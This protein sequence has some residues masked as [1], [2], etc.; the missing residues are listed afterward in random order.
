MSGHFICHFPKIIS[1]L[2]H[3]E[4]SFSSY[5]LYAYVSR[6]FQLNKEIAR[7]VIDT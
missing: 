3:Y 7:N 6:P 4:L 2:Q 5:K 1:P